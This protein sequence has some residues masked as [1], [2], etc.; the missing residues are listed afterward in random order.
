MPI[1]V[2]T[3]LTADSNPSISSLPWIG[4]WW[5]I[6]IV[7]GF[8]LIQGVGT[9]AVQV[10]AALGMGL[11]EG[12]GDDMMVSD[13]GV[14]VWVLPLSL[15]LSTL[16]A[17]KICLWMTKRFSPPE[18][19]LRWLNELVWNSDLN[20]QH[21]CILGIGVGIL[22]NLLT[23]YVAPPPEDLPQP[24]VEAML[25]SPFLM[26]LGWV[27]LMAGA[28]PVIEEV[29]FRGVLYTGFK[30]SWGPAVAF[31]LTTAVF[32]AFHMPKVLQYW[33]AAASVTLLGSFLLWIRIRTSSLA[34]GM[35]FHVS[36]NGLLM[37]VA[38]VSHHWFSHS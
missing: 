37:G 19:G 10:I 36:Y 12:L 22:F 17:F 21:Y 9:L 6:L 5:G 23:L 26:Q 30:Q 20:L 38:L 28:L 34:P 14:Q 25:S 35:V 11:T 7:G 8:Y 18:H 29:L 27:F 15:I 24:L 2:P 13:P 3:D 31:V 32:V 33:P 4:A 16:A 1:P